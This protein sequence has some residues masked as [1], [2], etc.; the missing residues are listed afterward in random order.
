MT[1]DESIRRRMSSSQTHKSDVFGSEDHAGV[2]L[3]QISTKIGP[4]KS[5]KIINQFQDYIH[6][7]SRGNAA[8]R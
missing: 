3:P 7:H 8:S 4:N 5:V 1:G 2:D 6:S